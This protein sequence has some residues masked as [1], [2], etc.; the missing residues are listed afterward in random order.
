MSGEEELI[1]E[2]NLYVQSLKANRQDNVWFAHARARYALECREKCDLSRDMM[3]GI[4]NSEPNA[5]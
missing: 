5:W 4:D 1:I 3:D 2:S